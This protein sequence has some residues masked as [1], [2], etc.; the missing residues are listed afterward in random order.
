MAISS[1]AFFVFLL[2]SLCIKTNG[3]FNG[4]I[5]SI[6]RFHFIP[7]ICASA[8]F[9]IGEDTDDDKDPQD[10]VVASLIFSIIGLLTL[11]I[12]HFKTIMDPW[13][14]SLV[15]KNGAFG[16]LIALF[17]YNICNSILELGILKYFDNLTIEKIFEEIFN[18]FSKKKN[19]LLKFINNCGT[20]LPLTIGIVNISLSL[21]LKDFM[22][23]VMNLLIF[24]GCTI[25]YYNLDD[26]IKDHFKD[27]GDGII[28]IIMI[29]LSSVAIAFLLYMYRGTYFK[30]A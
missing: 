23:S 21:A 10:L 6:S 14:I 24:I 27:N 29:V 28:D 8:L 11:I 26:Y 19:D 2:Y 7:L 5:G 30:L 16:C 22:I 13:Y 18:I 3:V 9:I 4:M 15:I 12:I 20:A 1:A 25:Y 17:T